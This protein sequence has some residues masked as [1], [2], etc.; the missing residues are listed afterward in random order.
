MTHV[1]IPIGL[2]LID[3]ICRRALG[4]KSSMIKNEFIH[5]C[6]CDAAAVD[7]VNQKHPSNNIFCAIKWTVD[8]T[9]E[10]EGTLFN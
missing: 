8:L 5:V 2:S 1:L 10:V 7:A 9:G 3:G 6:R 4:N